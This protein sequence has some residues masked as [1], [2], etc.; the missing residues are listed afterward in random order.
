MKVVQDHGIV[1]IM[2]GCPNKCRFC[3]ASTIYRPFRE[4]SMDVIIKEID[5]IVSNGGYKNV[6]LSSLSSGDYSAISELLCE[7]DR[8]YADK[9]VSFSLPSLKI[10]SFTF[11][12]LRKIASVRKSGLTFAVESA[13]PEHRNSIGKS[14]FY[15]N[16]L[17]ILREAKNQ[18]WK[19]A[20]LYFMIGLPFENEAHDDHIIDYINQLQAD[21]GLQ[22]NINIGTFIPK[23]HTPFQWEAQIPYEESRKRLDDLFHSVKN[24]KIKMSTH[25]P[26][27]SFIEGLIARGDEKV[28]QVALRAFQ[29]GA[30]FE[31]WDE[32][33]KPAVWLE[34][35]REILNENTQQYTGEK[36]PGSAQPWTVINTGVRTESLVRER[37]KASEKKL[38]ENCSVNCTD[39]CGACTSA[40]KVHV[41]TPLQ[42]SQDP[43]PESGPKLQ[44]QRVFILFSYTKSRQSIFISH[45]DTIKVFEQAMLRAGVPVSYSE[46]FNPK[47]RI[48]FAHPL[49]L[50]LESIDEIAL[51]E[52]GEEMDHDFAASMNSV[53]P[54]GVCINSYKKLY[55]ADDGK[56]PA[57]L[58]SVYAGSEFKVI[59]PDNKDKAASNKLTDLQEFINHE[60][61]SSNITVLESNMASCSFK[62]VPGRLKLKDVLSP[63]GCFLPHYGYTVRRM[64]TFALHN[65]CEAPYMEVY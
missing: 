47:A 60:S 11:G 34:S 10:N 18:G 62:I 41:A 2:R 6:T 12:L 5:D 55:T 45:L 33:L 35:I 31:A 21:S 13:C 38:P 15:Q 56:K 36:K 1:E 17:N 51:V 25:N 22:L 16:I 20:K 46:G 50:G 44:E 37:Q 52:T 43:T 49:M 30:R 42:T 29:N 26:F 4:K 40:H 57:S 9:R 24:R 48:T 3:Q 19:L 59:P 23:P 32:H 61:A 65:D 28:G 63:G 27:Q 39:Y 53:L 7:L 58:M 64:K 14:V 54:T 8:R